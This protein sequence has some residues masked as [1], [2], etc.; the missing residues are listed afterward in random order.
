M[1]NTPKHEAT[2]AM[3]MSKANAQNPL[4]GKSGEAMSPIAKDAPVM[5]AWE[6]Y[7]AGDSYQNTRR[8]ASHEEH[9]D[10]SLWAAFSAGFTASRATTQPAEQSAS[11]PVE[12][13]V[14]PGAGKKPPTHP[15][16]LAVDRFAAAMKAK[17]AQKRG[18][19]RGG[20][21]DKEDCSAQFLSDLLRGHV[22]KGDPLDVGNFA[23]MLHQRDEAI[24]APSL[25]TRSEAVSSE[26]VAEAEGALKGIAG[27]ETFMRRNKV[28]VSAWALASLL[29]QARKP[30]GF[31]T[32][33]VW[34]DLKACKIGVTL[35]KDEADRHREAGHDVEDLF[36]HPAHEAGEVEGAAR[37]LLN[38]LTD[39]ENRISTDEDGRE[40][41]GHVS[42]AAARLRAALEDKS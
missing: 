20:W 31:A 26:A 16:D 33:W 34:R 6:A 38:R 35:H 23:M 40:F 37:F 36:A 11:S 1:T 25:T 17:L 15:D 3:G 5:V 9:V 39:F 19:G 41:Y 27:N 18:E 14:F 10:G 28:S 21:D 22:E 30:E 8:W 13:E 2:D 29:N 4:S 32:A 24:C 12:G 42:P 7:K